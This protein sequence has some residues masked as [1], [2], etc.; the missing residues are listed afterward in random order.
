[1]APPPFLYLGLYESKNSCISRMGVS[2]ISKHS[3]IRAYEVSQR[4]TLACHADRPQ[5][6]SQGRKVKGV[7]W[8]FCFAGAIF[9]VS[10]SQNM[11]AS[12][13]SNLCSG[14]S[15]EPHLCDVD[16]FKSTFGQMEDSH[17]LLNL[18]ILPNNTLLK[19]YNSNPTL[20]PQESR[21]TSIQ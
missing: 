17:E 2:Q 7:G 20:H 8:D 5:F 12:L 1:M 19:R 14:V 18:L 10:F 9:Q 21:S 3:N 13:C 11:R 15:L 6:P 16:K 4:W